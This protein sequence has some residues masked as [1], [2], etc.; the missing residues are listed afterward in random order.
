M[1][2]VADSALQL[3][4]E[5]VRK[6]GID[7][8]EYPLYVNGKPYPVSMTMS[9]EEKDKLRLLLKDKNN[10]VTTSGLRK[11]DL[12]ETYRKYPDEPIVSLHQSGRASTATMQVIN[13]ILDEQSS[14]N[15]EFIDA[16]HLTA[17]YSVIVQQVAEA[18]QGGATLEEV[19]RVVELIR[20]RTRHLGAVYDLFYLHRT[21]RIGLAKAVLGSAM[22]IIALLSSS[23]E[24]G[25]LVS[26]GKSKNFNQSNQRLVSIIREDL[27]RRQG[28]RLRAVI[29]V[30]GPHET[31]AEH[32]KGLVEELPV[33]TQ[34][35]IHF[36]N[37]SN[38]PHA[39][40]DF[41]DI[42]YTIFSD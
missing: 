33:T 42:G 17:A 4:P 8:V 34:V 3:E 36:T 14:L 28:K 18:I 10:K 27:D 26:I 39:G 25:V 40:P 5:T 23:D 20:P 29:S 15:V 24:P 9:R 22:K 12:L 1:K 16:H 11:E 13:E 38:M 35:E 32:L 30:I 19:R 6:L 21:G 7:V 2:L 31:E 41:Y 37:H